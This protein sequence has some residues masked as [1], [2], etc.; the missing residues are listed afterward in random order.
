[1]ELNRSFDL[2]ESFEII[3]A[4]SQAAHDADFDQHDE[5][6]SSIA[7][8]GEPLREAENKSSIPEMEEPL[9]AEVVDDTKKCQSCSQQIKKR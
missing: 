4:V 7:E 8:I 5:E 6:K 2:G 3:S 9:T 1:M